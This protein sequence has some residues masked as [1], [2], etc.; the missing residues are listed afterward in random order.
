MTLYYLF[1]VCWTASWNSE[2]KIKA[3]LPVGKEHSV[4]HHAGP[5]S[6]KHSIMPDCPSPFHRARQQRGAPM[7]GQL[8]MG[9][10]LVG[11]LGVG[12][13][14][15]SLEPINSSLTKH[16]RE[17]SHAL[18][19]SCTENRLSGSPEMGIPYGHTG[20]TTQMKGIIWSLRIV[21]CAWVQF[22]ASVIDDF[23]EIYCKHI[24]TKR[25]LLYL[26]KSWNDCIKRFWKDCNLTRLSQSSGS[27]N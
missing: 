1:I 10:R 13:W 7:C 22:M 17:I 4:S 15:M 3:L 27:V 26:L 16:L 12:G 25:L 8:R 14:W 2:E 18:L 19:A 21:E 9:R 6:S 20:N 24:P 5:F 23:V 11:V